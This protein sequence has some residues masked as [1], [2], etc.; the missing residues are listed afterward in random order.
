MLQTIPEEA[1]EAEEAVSIEYGEKE[2]T[3][4]IGESHSTTEVAEEVAEVAEVDGNRT[5]GA[6]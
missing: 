5:G 4:E 3:V 6:R 1:I 2:M